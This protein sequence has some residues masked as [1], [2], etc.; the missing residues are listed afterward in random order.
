LAINPVT[1]SLAGVFPPIPTPFQ[2]DESLALDQLQRN[3]ERWNQTGLTGYV[4]GG[5]NG[6]FVYLSVEERLQVVRAARQAIPPGRLLIAGSGLESTR[7]TIALSVAMAEAGADAVIVVTP[8]YFRTRMDAA[9]YEWHYRQ[10]TQASPVPVVLYSVPANT[11]IELPAPAVIRLATEP[12]IIA[13]KDSGGNISRIAGLVSDTPQGFQVLAGSASFFLASLAVGAVGCIAALANVAAQQV[14]ELHDAF[15]AGNLGRARELQARL[16][17]PNHAVTAGYG[18]PGLKAALDMLG[19]YGGP[20][21]SPLQP[22]GEAERGD[23]R[24]I[25]AAAGVL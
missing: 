3:L 5:S 24:T 13:I 17:K 6:E 8:S 4:I 15:R 10:I 21:R 14:I 22:L 19:F 12:G 20:V 25:L 1:L 11:G 23:L 7:E 2:K 16:L 9:A 18:V